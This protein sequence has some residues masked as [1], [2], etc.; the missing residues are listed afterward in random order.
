[1]ISLTTLGGRTTRG[2]RHDNARPHVTRTFTRHVHQPHVI[3]LPLHSVMA[4]GPPHGQADI[5]ATTQ[6]RPLQANAAAEKAAHILRPLPPT[7]V[8]GTLP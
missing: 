7:E 1:M 6:C 4:A 8:E 5:L 2:H 3:T